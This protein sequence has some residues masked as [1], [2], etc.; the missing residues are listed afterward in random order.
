MPRRIIGNAQGERQLHCFCDASESAFGA[1]IYLRTSDES[2]ITVR[3]ICSK[4]QVAP[5]KQISLPRLE[6]CAAQLLAK[7]YDVNINAMNIQ[8]SRAYFWSDST[9]ALNWIKTSPLL[10]RLKTFVANRVSEIQEITQGHEWRHV[11]SADNPADALSRGQF[12][13]EF[14]KNQIWKQGPDWLQKGEDTWPKNIIPDTNIPEQRCHTI[15]LSRTDALEQNI[16]SIINDFSSLNKVPRIIA[17]ALRYIAYLRTKKLNKGNIN[18][19]EMRTALHYMIRIVQSVSFT[20]EINCLKNNPVDRK[21]KLLPLSPFLDDANLL[22]VGG[23]LKHSDLEYDNKYPI[24]LPH[25]NHLS[26]LLIVETHEKLAHAGTQT[27]L[28]ALSQGYWILN[29]KMYVKK[30]LRKCV[31]CFRAKPKIPD[32]LM[33]NLPRDRVQC[34]HPFENVGID[35]CGPFLVKEKKNFKIEIRSKSMSQYLYV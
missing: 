35:F 26:E 18:S 13:H 25:N 14:I 1:C 10:H 19:D 23:R 16:L 22:R 30:L 31:P 20:N 27:T 6:L 24:L 28:Y 12:P 32:H 29:G 7:L 3:L 9:I 34:S 21:N 17:Y 5:M 33:G 2:E 15:L 4:T 8:F 11:P